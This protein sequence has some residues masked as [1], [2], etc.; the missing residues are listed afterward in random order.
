M[1][2]PVL[3]ILLLVVAAGL[4]AAQ[5]VFAQLPTLV[6]AACQGTASLDECGLNQIVQVFINI[7]QFIFGV[8]G[9]IALLMFVWGGFLWLSS[10]GKAEQV[11][12]GQAVITGAV[13]GLIIIFG[14][15]VG[16]Q[17]IITSLRGTVAPGD[18]IVTG[19]RCGSGKEA[20]LAVQTGNP[21]AAST[22]G[23]ECIPFN[24]CGRIGEGWV[25]TTLTDSN[26]ASF[27]CVDGLV[28]R[29]GAGENVKCC[30]PLG[31][32]APAADAGTGGGASTPPAEGT[33]GRNNCTCADRGVTSVASRA[34][35]ESFCSTRDSTVETYAGGSTAPMGP[36]L[37]GAEHSG[38]A[39]DLGLLSAEIIASARTACASYDATWNESA[40]TC[41]G[42]STESECNEVDT[43]LPSEVN[44]TWTAG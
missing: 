7:A 13:I 19:E 29:P 4:F 27:E 41:T 23:L 40:L 12:Q 16:V 1:R 3:P 9:S 42:S 32:A 43:A 26:R 6:P 44:C 17:F 36:C 18:V 11:K 35:C 39:R 15:Y 5:P 20:G 21:A 8:S 25:E 33:S 28:T 10:A 31:G 30:R 38:L 14:A 2:R 34:L 22:S 37:C 24:Q